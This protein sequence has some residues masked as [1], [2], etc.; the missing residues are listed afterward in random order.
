M[1][2][3]QV[4]EIGDFETEI[5]AAQAYNILALVMNG[6]D[7]PLND[8]PAPSMKTYEKVMNTLKVKYRA[9]F[10]PEDIRMIKNM[11]RIRLGMKFRA[12]C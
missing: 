1:S 2:K 10:T 4:I 8:V 9:K 12:D 6:E 7:E 5:E 11:L 3:G